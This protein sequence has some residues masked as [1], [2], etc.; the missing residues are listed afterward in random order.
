MGDLVKETPYSE[1]T[2]TLEVLDRWGV[3]REH[4]AKFRGASSYVHKEISR[5]LILSEESAL[6]RHPTMLPIDRSTPFDPI[7]FIGD[8]WTIEEQDEGSLALTEVDLSKVRLETC[9]KKGED[10]VK[11][12]DKLKRLKKNGHIRLDAKV[13]QTLW[14]NQSLIPEHW[15]KETNGYTT[16]IFF[17]GTIVRSP[18]GRRCVLSL[19]FEGGEWRWA[20]FWLGLGWRVYRPSAVLAS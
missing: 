5:L 15:K 20:C 17:D 4:L 9:L 6:I 8:G 3:K 13:F 11:G 10:C 16:Y 14:E 2:S 7:K 1:V 12:E 19:F 18:P